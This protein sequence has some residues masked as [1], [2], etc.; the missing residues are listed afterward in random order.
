MVS[1]NDIL[2]FKKIA[3]FHYPLP[4]NL[5]NLWGREKVQKRVPKRAIWY[6]RT[7]GTKRDVGAAFN[8]AMWRSVED[9]YAE[10]PGLIC[11]RNCQISVKGHRCFPFDFHRPDDTVTELALQVHVSCPRCHD[12]VAHSC[13]SSSVRHSKFFSGFLHR[14]VRM[15]RRVHHRFMI[16]K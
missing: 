12:D 13:N 14:F 8:C 1:W 9:G 10:R 6:L 3:P 16:K 4:L 2:S 11:N 7:R 5:C 15:Y